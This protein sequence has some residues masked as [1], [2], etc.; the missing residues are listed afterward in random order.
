MTGFTTNQARF[1]IPRWRTL[2]ET[3]RAGELAPSTLHPTHPP[4]PHH[5]NQIAKTRATWERCPTVFSASDFIGAAIFYNRPH[6]ALDAIEFL[7]RESA[8]TEP[9]RES[10]EFA[11]PDYFDSPPPSPP[12]T[13]SIREK[14]EHRINELRAKIRIEPKRPI[15]QVDLALAHSTL[16]QKDKAALHITIAQQLAPNDRHVLR[17]SSRFWMHVRDYDQAHHILTKSDRTRSD[18][19]LMSA[20]VA[21]ANNIGKTPSFTEEARKLIS[22]QSFPDSHISELASAVATV[23][24]YRGSMPRAKRL[25]DR[26]LQD[27]TENSLAQA[28]WIAIK[29]GDMATDKPL[30]TFTNAYEARSYE[31]FA[32][33]E[34]E[35]AVKECEGWQRDQPFSPD[36]GIEGSFIL[37][38]ALDDFGR[39]RDFIEAS[40][41]AN[42]SDPFLHNNM[43]VA[44]IHLNDLTAAKRHI[45][46]TDPAEAEEEYRNIVRVG[47]LATEGLWNYRNGDSVRGS[48][49]YSDAL[50]LAHR[51]TPHLP[52][53]AIRVKAFHL[54]EEFK[55]NGHAAS[56]RLSEVIQELSK[57]DVSPICRILKDKLT[58]AQKSYK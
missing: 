41:L 33:G 15:T 50:D 3:F 28:I 30:P 2:E 24:W 36:P 13:L 43:A 8:I 22:E 4:A 48:Q 45:R 11:L 35:K 5:Y 40:L 14:A 46:L 47:K 9:L 17:S 53:L 56:Q 23:D 19:W 27:P 7:N 58:A 54:L 21:V 39:A 25:L 31:Y 49:L 44:L 55:L 26:S 29:D 10:I 6:E 20:E 57:H 18:P 1:V 38:S 42:P 16:G 52:D 51:L 37:I 34:W 12:S 32:Q